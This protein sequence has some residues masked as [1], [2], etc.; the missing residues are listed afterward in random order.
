ML[1]RS[2]INACLTSVAKPMRTSL[3]IRVGPR[4]IVRLPIR[5]SSPIFSGPRSSAPEQTRVRA[6]ITMAPSASSRIA[7]GS[8]TAVGSMRLAE[9][10]MLAA[11]RSASPLT[12]AHHMSVPRRL[13]AL[14]F[15]AGEKPAKSV[16][17]PD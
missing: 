9:A 13:V 12:S 10:E 11:T 3:P 2:P 8:I 5:Q 6:P 15:A 17:Q 16:D 4:T 7:P 1:T 14:R